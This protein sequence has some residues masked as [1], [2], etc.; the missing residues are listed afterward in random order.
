M[1]ILFVGVSGTLERKLAIFSLYKSEIHHEP[2][3]NSESAIH[4]LARFRGATVAVHYAEHACL[5][6]RLA[7]LRFNAPARS[8]TRFEYRLSDAPGSASS[9]AI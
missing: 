9:W 1:R 2:V 5:Y 8:Q 6:V 7:N 4:A 3:P